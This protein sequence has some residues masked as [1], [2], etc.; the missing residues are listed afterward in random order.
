VPAQYFG[1]ADGAAL[2]AAE[3]TAAFQAFNAIGEEASMTPDGKALTFL[4]FGEETGADAHVNSLRQ[5]AQEV[6][7]EGE[8]G[9]YSHGALDS[10]QEKDDNGNVTEGYSRIVR[11]TWDTNAPAG[12]PGIYERS[13][14]SLL[15]P[16]I[17]A[18]KAE[19]FGFDF[20]GWQR[21]KSATRQQ[22][23]ELEAKVAAAEAANRHGLVPKLREKVNSSRLPRVS[24][25][26]QICQTTTNAN[27]EKQL[28]ALDDALS[29][30]PD[31]LRRI[32][33][34]LRSR[35]RRLARTTYQ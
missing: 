35:L 19:G 7:L 6:G 25:G 26:A 14:D 27:A 9:G 21:V 1:R 12:S 18:I 17:L 10:F 2:T 29:S 20:A 33:R 22:R 32:V 8:Y 13:T 28:E 34:G 5:V 24:I 3:V 23:Q 15:V 16:Y 30:N 4:Y 31:P 11:E